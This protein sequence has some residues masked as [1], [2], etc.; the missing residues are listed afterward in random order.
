MRYIP[1]GYHVKK[2]YIVVC[3]DCNEDISRP[4]TGE[5]VESMAEARDLIDEHKKVFHP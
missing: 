2:T 3:E 1:A 5:D 4:V